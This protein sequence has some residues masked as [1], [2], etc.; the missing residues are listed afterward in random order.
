MYIKINHFLC[1]FDLHFL[2]SKCSMLIYFNFIHVIVIMCI[3]A[4]YVIET[5][6]HRSA[7][8]YQHMCLSHVLHLSGMLSRKMF[9]Y[10]IC[11]VIF[12]K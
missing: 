11:L 1:I 9:L 4:D 7:A 12:F 10:L 3:F 8:T 2:L 6:D 5:K